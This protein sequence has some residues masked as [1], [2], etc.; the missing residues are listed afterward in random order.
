MSASENPA[1]RRIVASADDLG[2]VER[3]RAGDE[4]AFATLIDRHHG[5]LLRLAR[6]YVR[7]ATLAEEV[8]QDTWIGLLE[9]LGRFEGRSSLKTW[10]FRILM[11]VMRSRLRKESRSVPFSALGD[12]E[13]DEPAVEPGRFHRTWMPL[14]GGHWSSAPARWEDLP[15]ERAISAERLVNRLNRW[16]SMGLKGKILLWLAGGQCQSGSSGGTRW[17]GNSQT[18]VFGR[19][20]RAFRRRRADWLWS[21]RCQGHGVRNSGSTTET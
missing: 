9:S 7:D 12:G 1:E 18:A 6:V 8:V 11:N 14:V 10:L 20:R 17:R 5:S 4:A 15:E 3:L 16:G 19:S 2:V 13:G 21:Q